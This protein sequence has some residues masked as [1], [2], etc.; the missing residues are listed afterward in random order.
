MIKHKID[1]RSISH[2]F[3]QVSS[4][5]PLLIN[6]SKR[7]ITWNSI[8]PSTTPRTCPKPAQWVKMSSVRTALH[9]YSSSFDLSGELHR[10]P[11]N[12]NETVQRTALWIWADWRLLWLTLEPLSVSRCYGWFGVFH[13]VHAK[14]NLDHRNPSC[15]YVKRE[16][17]RK[18]QVK[19]CV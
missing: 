17:Q 13:R 14:H 12:P 11:L 1:H 5:P 16:R 2:F 8:V 18:R 10:T 7:S 4:F 15:V 3:T 6:E 9:S 19:Q